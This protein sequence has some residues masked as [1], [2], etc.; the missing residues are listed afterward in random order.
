MLEKVDHNTLIPTQTEVVL[1]VNATASSAGN[2]N[3]SLNTQKCDKTVPC[4]NNES[5]S[6]DHIT[7]SI[8]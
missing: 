5:W 7:I 3:Q 6:G 8:I 1:T 2:I 4:I